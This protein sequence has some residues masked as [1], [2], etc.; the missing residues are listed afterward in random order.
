MSHRLKQQFVLDLVTCPMLSKQIKMLL[1]EWRLSKKNRLLYW[2]WAKNRL[3]L[4]AVLVYLHGMWLALC[5]EWQ[6]HLTRVGIFDL[7][8]NAG[9]PELL[10]WMFC[11]TCKESVV[12]YS[13][14]PH[15]DPDDKFTAFV[16]FIPD[17]ILETKLST[18]WFI[19][20]HIFIHGCL[21]WLN[22]LSMD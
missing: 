12:N 14:Y 19:I 8:P 1:I 17:V 7:L 4:M 22:E 2:S 6:L 10:W 3:N 11:L 5:L 16:V 9:P 21:E 18:T 13:V 20:T 15:C